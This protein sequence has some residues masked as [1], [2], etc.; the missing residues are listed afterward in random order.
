M[1]AFLR[2]MHKLCPGSLTTCASDMPVTGHAQMLSPCISAPSARFVQHFFNSLFASISLSIP[3]VLCSPPVLSAALQAPVGQQMY[4]HSS[5]SSVVTTLW[6]GVTGSSGPQAAAGPD[7]VRK[8]GAAVRSAAS[9][10]Q[11][12][13]PA[14]G[15]QEGRCCAGKC[16]T[17]HE[18]C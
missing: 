9:V 7:P 15:S 1:S 18:L 10:Q 2:H 3:S 16:K 13:G 5:M 4:C 14:S 17:P 12:W 11:A 6:C 8:R